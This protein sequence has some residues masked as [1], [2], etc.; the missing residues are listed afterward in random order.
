MEGKGEK[1][2]APTEEPDDAPRSK[3]LSRASEKMRDALWEM[4][5]SANDTDAIA[6]LV[7]NGAFPADDP[8]W[9][10]DRI[11]Q[12]VRHGLPEVL[13][14]VLTHLG[15]WPM[16]VVIPVIDGTLRSHFCDQYIAVFCAHFPVNQLFP[17]ALASCVA[18]HV[19]GVATV[20]A[21]SPPP[22][23]KSALAAIHRLLVH[24]DRCPRDEADQLARLAPLVDWNSEDARN[25]VAHWLPAAIALQ[26]K[27]YL[28]HFVYGQLGW[29]MTD[30]MVSHASYF[31]DSFTIMIGYGLDPR[32]PRVHARAKSMLRAW[33]EKHEPNVEK[34]AI[35]RTYGVRVRIPDWEV[36]D[37]RTQAWN[38][39]F[40]AAMATVEAPRAALVSALSPI[41][42]V[43]L[44]QITGDFLV[45]RAAPSTCKQ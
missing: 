8:W 28:L 23:S 12:I 7:E 15:P 24:W 30:D 20:V 43:E 4:V 21:A 19:S 45:L 1:R 9:R 29:P 22:S 14:W 11:G 18:R 41:L 5:A 17:E 37:Y 33:L 35:L 39:Q 27:R 16:E 42:P 25:H 10:T 38:N 40:E 31:P 26:G 36:N 44:A 3:R 32:S 34:L 6:V 2:P 13:D